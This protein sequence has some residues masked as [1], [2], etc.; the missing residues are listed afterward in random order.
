VIHANWLLFPSLDQ[1]RG[2]SAHRPLRVL[3]QQCCDA[4]DYFRHEIKPLWDSNS[5][6][7]AK[8]RAWYFHSMRHQQK[9]T[10]VYTQKKTKRK[11]NRD[12]HMY[13]DPV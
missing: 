12:I 4:C 1:D 8:T 3:G 13:T 7:V 2:V 9:T 11:S 10:V 5:S 6:S